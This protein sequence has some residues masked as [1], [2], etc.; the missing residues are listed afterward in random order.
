MKLTDPNRRLGAR[1]RIDLQVRHDVWKSLSVEVFVP[2]KNQLSSQVHSTVHSYV[3]QRMPAVAGKFRQL[4]FKEVLD[5]VKED[6]S[7]I[8]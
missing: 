4:A 8:V 2:T 5:Q 1:W 6:T 3:V 7:G